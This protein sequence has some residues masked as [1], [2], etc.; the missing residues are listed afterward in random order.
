[1]F[2]YNCTNND[3]MNLFIDIKITHPKLFDKNVLFIAQ[4]KQYIHTI[5][6]RTVY[7]SFSQNAI[8]LGRVILQINTFKLS[9]FILSLI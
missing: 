7:N 4:L 6:I 5:D 1:M 8:E 2:Q 9:V 3:R